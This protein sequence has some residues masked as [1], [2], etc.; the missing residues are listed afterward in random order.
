MNA[1]YKLTDQKSEGKSEESYQNV[2]SS[3]ESYVSATESFYIGSQKDQGLVQDKC[4][5]NKFSESLQD[6]DIAAVSREKKTKTKATTEPYP[7]IAR[8]SNDEILPRD[9]KEVALSIVSLESKP[10]SFDDNMF[11]L[12]E[13]SKSD[14]KEKGE[15]SRLSMHLT[16]CIK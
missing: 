1:K 10:S 9:R 16:L 4:L 15:F 12:T 13:S 14:E 5:E 6:I 7:V 8:E 11:P 2:I 3:K